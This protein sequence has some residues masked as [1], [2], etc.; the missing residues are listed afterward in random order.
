MTVERGRPTY[1]LEDLWRALDEGYYVFHRPAREG[2]AALGWT[3]REAVRCLRS[4]TPVGFRKS[5]P[6]RHIKGWHDVYGVAW[7]GE[8]VYIHFC[9]SVGGVFV[10]AAMKRDMGSDVHP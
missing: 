3:E 10:I 1:R 5:M 2:F 8:R 6:G 9:R 4:L 7:Q